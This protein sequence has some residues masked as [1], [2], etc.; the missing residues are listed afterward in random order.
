MR[1]C[2]I[3]VSQMGKIRRKFDPE[4][5]EKV[6]RQLIN[7]EIS[8]S[9]ASQEYLV[10]N[11]QLS[12]W[13]SRFKA[14]QSFRAPVNYQVRALTKENLKLKE[15]LAELYLQVDALK[16][17]EDYARRQKSENSFIVTSR[18]L[19]PLDRGAK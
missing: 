16:K 2:D 11:G 3:G 9:Q 13:V 18:S 10:S 4:L 15:K 7:K 6:A 1:I 17:M 12:Q 5:K 19:N 14:G 8:Y